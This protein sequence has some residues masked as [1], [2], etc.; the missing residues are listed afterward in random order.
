MLVV[1]LALNDAFRRLRF[2]GIVKERYDVENPKRGRGPMVL[3]LKSG[4]MRHTIDVEAP[5]LRL[6]R[7]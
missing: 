6:S 1:D 3:G 2:G 4:A 5:A 7:S